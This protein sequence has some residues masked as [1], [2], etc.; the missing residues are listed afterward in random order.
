MSRCEDEERRPT[1]AS[2]HLVILGHGPIIIPQGDECWEGVGRG[3]K[4]TLL[5]VRTGCDDIGRGTWN[6]EC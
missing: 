4:F 1:A 6:L 3:T 2:L 5:F